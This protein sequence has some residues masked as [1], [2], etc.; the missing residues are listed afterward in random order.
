MRNKS[1]TVVPRMERLEI[2]ADVSKVKGKWPAL[3]GLKKIASLSYFEEGGK[4]SLPGWPSSG[5]RAHKLVRE[6][7]A[8]L[9]VNKESR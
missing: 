2:G 6:R 4:T 1:R 3:R 5:H 7:L 8:L 9:A